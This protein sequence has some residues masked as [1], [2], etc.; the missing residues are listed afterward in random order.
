MAQ[1]ETKHKASIADVAAAVGVSKTTISRYLHK[2]Y[3]YMSSQTRERIEQVI[4]ELDYRPNKMAQGLKT[5][6]T[7]IIGATIANISNPFSS[8]LLKGIQSECRA[9]GIQLLVSDSDDD[10]L[11]ERTA[12]E[13]LIDSQ[14]D[15]LIINTVGGNDSYFQR[16]TT[17]S[18]N[19][20]VVML[21]RMV[22]PLVCDSVV[23]DNATAVKDMLDYLY[24]QDFDHI[25][26]VSQP[27]KGITTRATRRN[28]FNDYLSR[29]STS[30]EVLI[31]NPS[32]D[33][34]LNSDL[35]TGLNAI[36]H[37]HKSQKICLFANNE[38]AAC[39]ILEVLATEKYEKRFGLCAF[40]S[41]RWAQYSGTHGITC[42]DQN[43]V[44]MGQISAKRLLDRIYEESVLEPALIETP[45]SLHVF[46]STQL[47]HLA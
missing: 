43:P 26:F 13:A 38:D 7:R 28:A 16:F 22:T 25:V 36:A 30:G 12:V 32:Q 11:L 41:Q 37:K 4:K 31:F 9:R 17:D 47:T 46:G 8:Q 20:P 10:P 45:A 27:T 19:P 42:L 34:S 1:S 44:N 6:N 21:D 14:V 39:D 40:A 33:A 35:L 15:G 29:H 3:D 24:D 18:N 23:T 5:T 2:E